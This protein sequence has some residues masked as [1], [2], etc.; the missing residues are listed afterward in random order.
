MLHRV[1]IVVAYETVLKQC[2]NNEF[3][4]HCMTNDRS[5]KQLYSTS[6]VSGHHWSSQPS[7]AS[8]QLTLHGCAAELS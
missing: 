2:S 1:I 3:N 8:H 6:K 7:F 5:I 4:M